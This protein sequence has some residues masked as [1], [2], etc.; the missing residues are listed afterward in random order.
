[1]CILVPYR[2][3]AATRKVLYILLEREFILVIVPSD[4]YT[5]NHG[6]ANYPGR[7]GSFPYGRYAAKQY[8]VIS[9]KGPVQRS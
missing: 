2:T 1:M 3:I 6:C 7:D 5:R 4:D 8:L 9:I